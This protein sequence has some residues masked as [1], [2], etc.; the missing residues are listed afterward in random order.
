MGIRAA[1]GARAFDLYVLVLREGMAPVVLGLVA[2][3]AVALAGGRLLSSMLFETGARDPKTIGAVVLLLLIVAC[4]AC[5]IPARRASRTDP[6][7]AL[8]YE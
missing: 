7:A 1:L 8:H 2:G 6:A 5:L 3:V 4:I